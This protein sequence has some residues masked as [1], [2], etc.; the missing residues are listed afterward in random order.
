M[1][2][3]TVTSAQCL[4]MCFYIIAD[5]KMANISLDCIHSLLKI[6]QNTVSNPHLNTLPSP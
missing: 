3:P 2:N 4:S 1:S 6:S 5:D